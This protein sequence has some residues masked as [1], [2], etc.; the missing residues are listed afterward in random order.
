MRLVSCLCPV[1]GPSATRKSVSHCPVGDFCQTP[2]VCRYSPFLS[3]IWLFCD[4][5]RSA[6]SKLSDY[7]R[8]QSQN[9]AL[10]RSALSVRLIFLA[11]PG[12]RRP[13]LRVRSSSRT[14]S[15]VYGLPWAE[16]FLFGTEC[17]SGN[18]EACGD[19]SSA[20]DARKQN[21]PVRGA[22]SSRRLLAISQRIAGTAHSRNRTRN[23]MEAY[24]QSARAASPL[25]RSA[26]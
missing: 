14:S 18:A 11:I 21:R 5:V 19:I 10:R 2:F 17:C 12:K 15:L 9:P 23:R 13:H 24:Q 8:D 6:K 26:S 3:C 16:V 22:R 7:G 1:G 4:P 20:V 25:T